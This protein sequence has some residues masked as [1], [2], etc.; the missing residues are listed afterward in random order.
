MRRRHPLQHLHRDTSCS[1]FRCQKYTRHG[2]IRLDTTRK[3]LDQ[4]YTFV[5]L[6]LRR[7]QD[8]LP[9]RGGADCSRDVDILRPYWHRGRL[10]CGRLQSGQQ[11][12]YDSVPRHNFHLRMV[13]VSDA[14]ACCPA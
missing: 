6:L 2:C 7:K 3:G 14:L 4:I 9:A 8:T 13:S 1:L 5:R 11:N 10:R 12:R